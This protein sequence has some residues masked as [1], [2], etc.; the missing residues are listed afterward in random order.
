MQVDQ[1]AVLGATG[2]GLVEA[3]APQREKGRRLADQCGGAAQVGHI[4]AAQTRHFARRVVGRQAAQGL[5]AF[6]VSVDIGRVVV[7]V[8]Q[9][10]VQQAVEQRHIG[11]WGDG[12]VQ[13]GQLAGV[14]APW[15][16]DDDRH[17]GPRRLGRFQA[18][19]QDRMR[20]GHVAAGDQQ[21]VGL[22]DILVAAGRGV[23][24]QAAL[25][26]DHRR[27]HAQA[28][29]AVDVVGAD[30]G[31]GQLVEGVVVLGQQLAG[32][33]EGHAVR[34]VLADGLGEHAGGVVEG[35]VPAA[36]G[37]GHALA[38]AQLGV[39]G[40]G[41]EVAGQVQGR[42]LAAQAAEVGRVAGV[43]LHPEDLLA[44]VLDQHAAA[45]AAVAAGG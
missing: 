45:D 44:I 17:L 26:A 12:Q 27:A 41:V 23:G 39:E 1:R 6:G 24:T 4:D 19:E 29:V 16:D 34:A 43:A 21:A 36:A 22:L 18:T 8:G 40:A 3:H 13:V 37:T 15:V 10:Q 14:G 30:Q 42:A 2:R 25:V 31:A 28:R 32:D 5:E 38:Q 9:Q 20:V 7:A 11:A 33:V 35:A